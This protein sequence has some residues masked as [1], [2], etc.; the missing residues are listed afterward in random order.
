[1]F[2]ICYRYDYE[3]VESECA[4]KMIAHLRHLISAGK[5]DF[6]GK[7]FNQFTVKEADDFEY[8]DPI[9]GSVSKNQVID[10]III[11]FISSLKKSLIFYII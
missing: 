9:D 6:I 2:L 4:N 11:N 8:R 1:M 5:D 3:E 10:C 7:T